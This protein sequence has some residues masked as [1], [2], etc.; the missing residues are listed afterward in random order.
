MDAHTCWLAQHGKS[1]GIT[2]NRAREAD[3]T[4]YGVGKHELDR[5][6][7]RTRKTLRRVRTKISR[8]SFEVI[9]ARRR[10]DSGGNFLQCSVWHASSAGNRRPPAL[11]RLKLADNVVMN[12]TH[13]GEYRPELGPL[14]AGLGPRRRLRYGGM[15]KAL[16]SSLESAIDTL[17]DVVAANVERLKGSTTVAKLARDSGVSKGSIQRILGGSKGYAGQ[18]KSAAQVD[19]LMRLAWHFNVPFISLFHSR[20][21]RAVVLA[22]PPGHD[23]ES[24]EE[25]LERRRS[26]KARSRQ[27]RK[28]TEAL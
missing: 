26:H 16:D 22:H 23:G 9:D 21:R 1:L 2:V 25:E 15:K 3:T 28:I 20:D 27:A 8:E 11:A 14:Q 6:K 17:L 13:S 19:T 18:K 12:G 7:L 10:A 5:A 24:P 4:L